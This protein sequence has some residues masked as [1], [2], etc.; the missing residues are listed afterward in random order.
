M[1]FTR[2]RYVLVWAPGCRG[3]RPGFPNINVRWQMFQIA[4]RSSK[5]VFERSFCGANVA[6][7]FTRRKSEKAFVMSGPIVISGLRCR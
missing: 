3:G 2:F 5:A 7:R 1:V 6:A 4:R